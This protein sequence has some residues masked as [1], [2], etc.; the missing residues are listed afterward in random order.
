MHFRAEQVLHKPETGGVIG[1][2]L[3]DRIFPD[4]EPT[5]VVDVAPAVTV[6]IQ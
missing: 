4:Q 2:L 5:L 6:A 1:D 3:E